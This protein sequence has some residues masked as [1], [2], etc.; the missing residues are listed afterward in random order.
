MK[1][2]C[3]YTIGN[4]AQ[5]NLTNTG[6]S[7]AVCDLGNTTSDIAIGGNYGIMDCNDWYKF[8]GYLSWKYRSRYL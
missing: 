3:N 4:M 7:Q 6:S 8:L 2:N 1:Q 5:S